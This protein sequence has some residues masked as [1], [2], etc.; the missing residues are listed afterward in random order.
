MQKLIALRLF[1]LMT[2]LTGILYPLLI[3]C[4]AMIFSSSS[5]EIIMHDNKAVGY[6][7]IGQKFE[8]DK[9]FYSRPSANDYNPLNSGGSNFGP[10]NAHLRDLV[11]SRKEKMEKA[12]GTA[13]AV[14]SELLFSSGSGLDPH[15]SKQAAFYQMD[16]ILKARNLDASFKTKIANLIEDQAKESSYFKLKRPYVNVLLLNIALDNLTK[17]KE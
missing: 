11:A 15:I 10:T 14:P 5:Y 6:R 2:L 4:F 13:L 8:N 17:K 3:G 12:H 16:R 7:L 9:Y 1:L